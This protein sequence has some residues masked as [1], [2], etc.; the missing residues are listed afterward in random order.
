MENHFY[1]NL[2]FLRISRGISQQ[3]IADKIGVN[4]S[5][6][7]YWENNKADPTMNNVIELAALLDISFPDLICK[8]LTVENTISN[9]KN[10]DKT[11]IITINDNL[12]IGIEDGKDLTYEDIIRVQQ[13]LT[14][15][16]KKELDNDKN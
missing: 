14:D 11:K 2:K 5:T 6:I 3:Y 9:S 8:D 4:R 16:L 1:K 12:K 13:I 7:S 15:E 10:N